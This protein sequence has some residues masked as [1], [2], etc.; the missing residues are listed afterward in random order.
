[1]HCFQAEKLS[2]R[3]SA[4]VVSVDSGGRDIL[5]GGRGILRVRAQKEIYTLGFSCVYGYCDG[6]AYRR[7][8]DIRDVNGKGG[9]R[10]KNV[11]KLPF[12]FILF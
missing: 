4:R 11:R 7:D 10:A 3:I 9:F 6:A 5:H 2:E 12:C 1:M 8:R